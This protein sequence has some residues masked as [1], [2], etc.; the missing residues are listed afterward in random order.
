MFELLVK[1]AASKAANAAEAD[2][3]VKVASFAR[4]ADEEERTFGE[5]INHNKSLRGEP[6]TKISKR[7]QAE[8]DSYAAD[9][10]QLA[11]S[12]LLQFESFES[13]SSIIHCL[14]MALDQ[15]VSFWSKAHE[16]AHEAD[17]PLVQSFASAKTDLRDAFAAYLAAHYVD[18]G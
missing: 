13:A 18:A 5:R 8:I 11:A 16:K 7:K 1:L 3:L 14:K 9:A 12:Q 4:R 6:P 2:A 15:D 10:E 17:R